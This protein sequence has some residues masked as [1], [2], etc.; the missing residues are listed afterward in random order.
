MSVDNVVRDLGNG[1]AVVAFDDEL[2]GRV[3]R[4]IAERLCV[5]ENRIVPDARFM[6]DLAADSLDLVELALAFEEAFSVSIPDRDMDHFKT[7]GSA[8]EQL[9]R[10]LAAQQTASA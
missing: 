2:L 5:E 3:R 4:L 10:L 7:V 6:E 9:S 8:V 1:Q